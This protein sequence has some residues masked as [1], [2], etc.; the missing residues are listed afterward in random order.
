MAKNT[1]K[2]LPRPI[3]AR[4][5]EEDDVQCVSDDRVLEYLRVRMTKM[6]ALATNLLRRSE[7]IVDRIHG[8]ERCDSCHDD[9]GSDFSGAV[10]YIDDEISG[11]MRVLRDLE[12][13]I[14]ALER[15]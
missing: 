4:V 13:E 9:C 8:E 15:L 2:R 12:T 11:M 14:N 10:G 1:L 5:E 7:N 3:S 6:N